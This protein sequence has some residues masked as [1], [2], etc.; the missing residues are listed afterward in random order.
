MM[1]L[2]HVKIGYFD[3]FFRIMSLS[4]LLSYDKRPHCSYEHMYVCTQRSWRMAVREEQ[5]AQVYHQLTA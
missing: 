1:Q 3:I 4:C 5:L 2:V